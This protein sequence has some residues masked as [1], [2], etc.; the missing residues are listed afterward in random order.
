MPSPKKIR[1]DLP[2][3]S[4]TGSDHPVVGQCQACGES[5]RLPFDEKDLGE[6]CRDCAKLLIAAELQQ[7]FPQAKWMGGPQ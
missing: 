6:I 3:I 4:V 2:K 1:V 7:I 5:G